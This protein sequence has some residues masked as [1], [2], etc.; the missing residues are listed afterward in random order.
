MGPRPQEN[1]MGM[2]AGALST[3]MPRSRLTL[4]PWRQ[5][6]ALG[7][8]RAAYALFY[9]GVV[10]VVAGGPACIVYLLWHWLTH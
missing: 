9:A 3:P 5:S 1:F 10:A 4:S 8:G 2:S 6:V 7:L